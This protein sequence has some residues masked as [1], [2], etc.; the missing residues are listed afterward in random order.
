MDR[1]IMG[2]VA[3]ERLT[4]PDVRRL[5]RMPSWPA[6]LASRVVLMSDECQAGP[7]GRYRTMPT[8]PAN[9]TLDPAQRA[10][11]QRYLVGVD[12]LLQ[13]TPIAGDEWELATLVV[14]TEF[15]LPMSSSQQNEAGAEA[16]GKAYLAALDDVPTWAVVAAVRRWHRGECG[17]N[18][19]GQ[20][21][22][23][24]WR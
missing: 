2:A 16:V 7:D 20:A 12:A 5:D 4:L 14:L 3:P 6:W 8:L 1:A 15:I 11:I 17:R 9:S 22:D 23:Y 19:R 13:Q 18:E 10:E 24:H 21:Y